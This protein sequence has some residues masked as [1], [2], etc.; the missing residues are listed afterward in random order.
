MTLQENG[1]IGLLQKDVTT[2]ELKSILNGNLFMSASG[3][4][5]LMNGITSFRI[6]GTASSGFNG[7]YD[8]KIDEFR[9]WN[10][11]LDQAT[12]QNWMHRTVDATHPE[13]SHLKAA[14][15]FNELTGLTAS[16]YSGNGHA[17]QLMGLP[18]WIRQKGSDV[19][20]NIDQTSF[21]Q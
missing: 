5:R 11:A 13:I 2:G 3:K 19:F 1:I 14:Y 16:D 12:I 21:S 17:S 18:E 8:G 15:D 4:T 20:I 10:K 9:I 7:V 6:G